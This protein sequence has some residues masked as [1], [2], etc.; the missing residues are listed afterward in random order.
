MELP[1]GQKLIHP[2]T[3]PKDGKTLLLQVFEH[4]REQNKHTYCVLTK[5]IRLR[6][7][8]HIAAMRL[9]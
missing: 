4:R 2:H 9:S 3:L 8:E 5:L 6:P 7:L 1:T